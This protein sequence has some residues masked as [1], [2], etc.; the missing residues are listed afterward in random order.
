MARKLCW[1][2]KG[3]FMIGES[4]IVSFDTSAHNRLV[5]P[6]AEPIIARI[7]SELWFR[8]AGSCVEE[9]SAAAGPKTAT[10]FASCQSLQ[11]GPSECLLPSNLLTEQLVSAHFA[12]P[13]SFNWKTLNVRWS[14]CE[15]AIRDPRF[16]DDE[17]TAGEQ[18]D[19]SG[20]GKW[21]N[22]TVNESELNLGNPSVL[23][24]AWGGT[25]D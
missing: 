15:R 2:L 22:R 18:R 6:D 13:K 21:W 17:Q 23:R 7:N 9:L 16:F 8:F 3:G 10:S 1:S 4:P 5:G 14:D 19:S 20:N 25:A 12:D 24:K 11:R